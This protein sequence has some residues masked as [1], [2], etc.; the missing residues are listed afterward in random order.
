ML[1]ILHI[2]KYVKTAFAGNRKTPR[3]LY[4]YDVFPLEV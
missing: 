4:N 2:G 1:P 3:R